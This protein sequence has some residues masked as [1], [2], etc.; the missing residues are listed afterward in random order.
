[1][2]IYGI[3]NCDT[4]KKA[5]KWL[6]D[7]GIE[8][9]FLDLRADGLPKE[10]LVRWIDAIDRDTGTQSRYSQISF[11]MVDLELGTIVWSGLYEMRKAAKDNVVYR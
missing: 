10:E 1:M 2:K 9:Q 8:H 6:K 7:E 5:I 3:K 11:E 4:C